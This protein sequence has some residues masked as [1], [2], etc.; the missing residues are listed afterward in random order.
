MLAVALYNVVIS[1][2]ESRI[3]EPQKHIPVI[4]DHTNS[5]LFVLLH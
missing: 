5:K 4:I 3:F 1:T 2:K